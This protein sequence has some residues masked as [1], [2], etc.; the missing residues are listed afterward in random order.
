MATDEMTEQREDNFEPEDERPPS[1]TAILW[2]DF[3]A[4]LKEQAK[5]PVHSIQRTNIYI[6]YSRKYPHHVLFLGFLAPTLKGLK[7]DD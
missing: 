1:Q 4:K 5:R 7:R 3:K 2:R 6:K